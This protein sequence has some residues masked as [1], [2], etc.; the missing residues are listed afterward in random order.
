MKLPRE[1]VTSLLCTSTVVRSSEMIR[2]PIIAHQRNQQIHPVIGFIDSLKLSKGKGFHMIATIAEK[3]KVQRSQRSYE[4]HFHLIA[5]IAAIAER[6]FLSDRS[7]RMETR[8]GL[9]EAGL[10]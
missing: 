5:M 8:A 4:N 10:R 7:D 9:F 2:N 6:V 3:K 1:F